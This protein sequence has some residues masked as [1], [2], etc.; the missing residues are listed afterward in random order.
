[1]YSP[2]YLLFCGCYCS[3]TLRA[4]VSIS[5]L[6]SLHSLF[7]EI[8]LMSRL[9]LDNKADSYTFLA[10]IFSPFLYSYMLLILFWV[11]YFVLICIFFIL[12]IVFLFP[13]LSSFS[14]LVYCSIIC[15]SVYQLSLILF[16]LINRTS[17]SFIAKFNLLKLRLLCLF[18]KNF[19]N[20]SS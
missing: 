15:F 2:S 19:P 16:C 11:V 9:L 8:I 4:V 20:Q 13:S 14:Q 10:L 7:C 12:W 18:V 5:L 3:F 6:L 1:M 17:E